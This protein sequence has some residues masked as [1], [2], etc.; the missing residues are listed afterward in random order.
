MIKDLSYTA[1]ISFIPFFNK[2][3]GYIEKSNVNKYLTLFPTDESKDKKYEEL[4]NK[5]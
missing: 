1:N 3:N 2:I 5:I 4:R